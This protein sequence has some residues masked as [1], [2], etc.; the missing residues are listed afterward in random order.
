[1]PIAHSADADI[2]YEV[3][4]TGDPVLLIMG[5]MAD[6]RMWAM[7]TP[8]LAPHHTVV[9]FDNRGVGNSSVPPGPYTMAQ[10]AADAIAVLDDAGIERAHVVGISMGG[11]IAQHVALAAPDRVRSLTLAATW[12]EPNEYMPRLSEVGSRIAQSLGRD[13]LVRTAMLWI[14]SPKFFIENITV[15]EAIEQMAI[16]FHPSPETYQNQL[17]AI[18]SHDTLAQ[19]A[20]LTMPVL[21]LTGRRDVMVPPEL[22]RALA[23][24][25][26]GCEF[27]MFESAHGFNIEEAAAF[28]QTLLDFLAK[29]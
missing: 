26:G 20:S 22:G 23:D 25:I 27:H 14:F 19:L 4:G 29:H 3:T 24:A 12:C 13:M 15:V 10:M 17:A 2:A 7:Q 28:N 18:S 16:A 11:A 6:A 9:T 8:A 21:V 5:F 1:M